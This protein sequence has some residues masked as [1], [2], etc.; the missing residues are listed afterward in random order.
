[1]SRPSSYRPVLF[2]L[3]I[4]SV[5][6][7]LYRI[8]NLTLALATFQGRSIWGAEAGPAASLILQTSHI[9]I[10]TTEPYVRGIGKPIPIRDIL[11]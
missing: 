9:K 1:M 6:W 2:L 8:K 11:E 5:V 3:F 10:R 4:V 7:F